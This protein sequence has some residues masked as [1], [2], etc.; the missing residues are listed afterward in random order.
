MKLI[1]T[2]DT[3]ADNQW[4]NPDVFFYTN[5]KALPDFDKLCRK[6]D[7]VPTYLTT[8]DVLDDTESA[9][10]IKEL[11]LRGSEV[12]SHL[13]SWSTPPVPTDASSYIFS[14]E[15]DTKTL[16]AQIEEL[17]KK[18]LDVT[19]SSP[20]SF[21][22]GRW[23]FTNEI[24][25]KLAELGYIVD[26]SVTPGVN[27]QRIITKGNVSAAPNYELYP[28]EPDMLYFSGG[29]LLEVPM[30]II[31]RSFMHRLH[32]LPRV[33]H[34]LPDKA[35]KIRQ[36]ITKPR[37]LRIFPE[38]T[39]KDL[40]FVYTKAKALRLPA[41]VFMIHSS[42][43]IK[44]GSPYTKTDAQVAHMYSVLEDFLAFA[45]S[46]GAE[47]ITLSDFAKQYTQNI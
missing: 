42:E 46:D 24:G 34:N 36:Y 11:H 19:D 15:L 38:T 21:R 25:N 33:I 7:M 8:Y 23:S 44:G 39:A 3:E 16:N 40:I 1:I 37:W 18:V 10:I 31:Q 28:V 45:S 9:R 2:V 5:I 20:T 27:W 12:G 30:T 29:K 32:G 13:H 14:S 6:F 43:L 4:K 22:G 47:G 41:I 35:K 17:T 26:S